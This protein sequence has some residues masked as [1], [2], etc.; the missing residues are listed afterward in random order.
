M[1][2]FDRIFGKKKEEV[3]PAYTKPQNKEKIEKSK[4]RDG[5]NVF[6]YHIC[7]TIFH[8]KLKEKKCM[9]LWFH[10]EIVVIQ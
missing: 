9:I 6:K 3:K 4:T 10:G 8:V 5:R 7:R 1:S 2:L